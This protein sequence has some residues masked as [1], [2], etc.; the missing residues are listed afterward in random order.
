MP[1]HKISNKNKRKSTIG[2]ILE[3]Y[4]GETKSIAIYGISLKRIFFQNSKSGFK[5]NILNNKNKIINRKIY[6]IIKNEK[7]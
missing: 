5:V 2:E 3:I 6:K 1:Q 4:T 7:L